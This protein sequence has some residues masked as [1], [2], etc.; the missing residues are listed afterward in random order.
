MERSIRYVGME[1]ATRVRGL[2]GQ[3]DGEERTSQLMFQPL[4][5]ALIA[6]MTFED[7]KSTWEQR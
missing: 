1:I 7:T 5:V 4:T 3:L 6:S 2:I